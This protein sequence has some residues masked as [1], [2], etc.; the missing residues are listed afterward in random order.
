MS[1][2]RDVLDVGAACGWLRDRGLVLAGA[3][4]LT[5]ACSG[6]RVAVP[7]VSPEEAARHAL[8]DH[9]SNGDGLLDAKELER[10]PALKNSLKDLDTS[11]DSRLSA[12]EIA[13]RIASY[14]TQQV[15]LVTTTCTVT[16]NGKA[17]AEAMVTLVPEKFLGSAVKPASG[18]TDR[19]GV[20][21]LRT[22]GEEVPGMH[23]G[24]FRVEV[25]KKDSNGKETLPT[26][27]NLQT[28]LGEEV[29][30]QRNSPSTGI[31]LRLT[32]P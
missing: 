23:C 10:C 1:G 11:G 8:A 24:F 22:E 15:G 18:V 27:Y 26:R 29:L 20:A 3:L 12:E 7:R 30:P 2:R 13:A 21:F 25:S 4:L 16:L 5:V 17:L 32:S 19:D 28:V 9:D 14:Q 31:A 6:D